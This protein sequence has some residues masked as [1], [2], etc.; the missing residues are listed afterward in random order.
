MGR[1]ALPGWTAGLK[2]HARGHCGTCCSAHGGHRR[3]HPAI[4]DL[5]P[6]AN[7]SPWRALYLLSVPK[8]R[9]RSTDAMTAVCLAAVQGQTAMP[10]TSPPPGTGLR[11]AGPRAFPTNQD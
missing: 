6:I 2:D 7:L 8:Q 3:R 9:G 11:V 10:G 5:G 4:P 1:V